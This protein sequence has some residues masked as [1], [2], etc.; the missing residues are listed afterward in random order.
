[1]NRQGYKPESGQ[2]GRTQRVNMRAGREPFAR[3]KPRVKTNQP[4][5]V[6]NGYHS[7]GYIPPQAAQRPAPNTDKPFS[8]KIL[9]VFLICVIAGF[10]IAGISAFVHYKNT[11]SQVAVYDHLFC[12]GVFIDDIDMGGM[13]WQDGANAVYEHARETLK[14]WYVRLIFRDK[15]VF[16]LTGDMVGF[17]IKIDDVL[18][19]AWEL[20]HIGNIF[21][22]KAA[23]DILLSDNRRFYT[24]KPDANNMSVVDD[25]L[26]DI[27][28]SAFKEA[29]DARILGFDPS[30]DSPFTY[31]QEEIGRTLD[32]SSIKETIYEMVS[33]M[34]AGDIQIEPMSVYPSV[35]V[36]DLKAQTALRASV[37]TEISKA[38]T[39]N[40]T[41]NIRVSC[42]RINGTQIKPGGEFSFNKIVGVRDKKN[43]FEAIEFAN[44]QEQMGYGGGVCQTSTTTYLAALKAGLKI[45]NRLP[46]SDSVS[47]TVYGQDATVSSVKGHEIDFKFKNNTEGTIYICSA[48]QPDPKNKNRFI[49]KVR[50]YGLD[51]GGISYKLE[52]ETIEKLPIPKDPVYD[53]DTD[54]TYVTYTDET[55]LRSKGK[56]GCVVETYLCTLLNNRMIDR[57]LIT[58]DRYNA[59]PDRYW[60]GT[61]KR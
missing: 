49:C 35:T 5:S 24:V 41:N 8:A 1:M 7:Y 52:S 40:R 42:D 16:T 47:Y 50:I 58:T 13:P 18:R 51:M 27:Q 55:K 44:G 21:E 36:A 23:R 20:G 57:V 46:H 59:K 22:R 10:A 19:D 39:A 28:R 31:Q 25:T 33:H 3:Q 4:R 34:Q 29:A 56:E 37:T 43:F 53:K 15:P 6:A 30:A 61:K 11:E 54:Q 14:A 48:V 26:L 9:R 12:P 17:E 45:V 38:S 2:D 60:Q 32:I